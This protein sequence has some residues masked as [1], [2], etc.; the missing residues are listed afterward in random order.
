MIGHKR[1]LI[2]LRW[3]ENGHWG[4]C[5]MDLS[6][7]QLGCSLLGSMSMPGP[8][9][10]SALRMAAP[11]AA[12]VASALRTLREQPKIR[13]AAVSISQDRT[14]SV[15]KAIFYSPKGTG[16][17][18]NSPM[19]FCANI[20][21]GMKELNGGMEMLLQLASFN[22]EG[23]LEGCV[24]TAFKN[25]RKECFW[26]YIW[27]KDPGDVRVIYKTNL[28]DRATNT[29]AEW[30]QLIPAAAGCTQPSTDPKGIKFMLQFPDINKSPGLEMWKGE[31][32]ESSADAGWNREKVQRDV[33]Q[34]GRSTSDQ[35]LLCKPK[36][37]SILP[38]PHQLA[39]WK[40]RLFAFHAE[41]P[42]SNVL[43][44][45]PVDLN[46]STNTAERTM[47]LAGMPIG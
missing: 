38:A 41:H 20:V 39:E 7:E 34:M 35:P 5:P 45:L 18:C 24:S 2:T 12:L 37:V 36:N 26:R 11:C 14:F 28:I 1:R 42:T 19:E 31:S 27:D 8:G 47:K 9:P 6:K 10:L 25:Y 23:C 16:L 43:P 40:A 46:V 13:T 3:D 44:R 4:C 21:E 33:L 32:D 22:F 29:Q 30:K 15:V 17:G